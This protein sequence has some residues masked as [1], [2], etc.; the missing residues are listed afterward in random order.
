MRLVTLLLRLGQGGRKF[1]SLSSRQPACRRYQQHLALSDL[2]LNI[3]QKSAKWARD[4]KLWGNYL[5]KDK[6]RNVTGWEGIATPKN[7]KNQMHSK[8]WT[9]IC[10]PLPQKTAECAHGSGVEGS[11]V[12]KVPGD[13]QPGWWDLVPGDWA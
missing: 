9:E 13:S 3:H 11:Q 8:P 2:P 4:K 10:E 6:A 7:L 12:P 5:W 1:K